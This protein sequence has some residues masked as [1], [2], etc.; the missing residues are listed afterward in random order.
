MNASE[1]ISRLTALARSNPER[2]ISPQGVALR[3]SSPPAEAS[4]MVRTSGASVT[5]EQSADSGRYRY[6]RA[7]VYAA[8][9][10]GSSYG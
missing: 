5:R 2:R 8:G 1:F 3:Q 4:G 9:K 7:G 10:T 6:R